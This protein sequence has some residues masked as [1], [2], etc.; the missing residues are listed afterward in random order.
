[1][2][3]QGED[4]YLGTRKK[5]LTRHQIW[6]CLELGR[7]ASRNVRDM[8]LLRHPVYAILLQQQM[9]EVPPNIVLILIFVFVLDVPLLGMLHPHPHPHLWNLHFP[10]K[11]PSDGNHSLSC[12]PTEL[13]IYSCYRTYTNVT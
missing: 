13:G 12:P 9:F 2:R 7:P 8:F 10:F 6:R 11:A 4:G 3:A 5:A 1:M